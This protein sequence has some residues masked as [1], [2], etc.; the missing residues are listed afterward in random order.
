MKSLCFSFGLLAAVLVTVQDGHA[1]D[2]YFELAPGVTLISGETWQQ[3]GETFRLYGVQSCLRGTFYTAANGQKS[4]CGDSAI[5]MLGAFIKDTHP[6]CAP[7]ARSSSV[8]YVSCYVTLGGNRLDFG[9]M[10]ISA[11]WAFAALGRNGE[12]YQMS[13]LVTEQAAKDAGEGLWRYPDLQHPSLI[14]SS[15]AQKENEQ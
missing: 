15:Q 10:L 11:G 7:V 9:T 13:Y 4:D 6:N 2:G 12:P 3:G 14:V 1:R 5:A 8:T